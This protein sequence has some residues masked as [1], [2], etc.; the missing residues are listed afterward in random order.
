M[1]LYV[2]ET[3]AVIHR[4]ADHLVV[5][6]NRTAI[7]HAPAEHLQ[8]VVIVGTATITTPALT[9]CFSRDISV[10][11]LSA[12]GS[13]KGQLLPKGG[14]HALLRQRQYERAQDAGFCL[15]VAKAVVT[16]KLRNCRT[17]LLRAARR[18]ASGAR[19][20]ADGLDQMVRAAT[21]ASSID[22][23]RGYE[24][25]GAARYFE[26]FAALLSEPAVFTGRTRRPP[27]DP[28]NALLS[29]G[30]TLL[31][32]AMI[33]L[34]HATGLDPYRGIFHSIDEGHAALASDLIE[35][36]RP[37]I[38]DS[39]VLEMVNRGGLG[40]EDF[41]RERDRVVLSR[42]GRAK[43]LR[44]YDRRLYAEVH[45][46]RSNERTTYLRCLQGQAR[47]LAKVVLGEQPQYVPFVVR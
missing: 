5:T 22:S 29:F 18:G 44:Q 17:L 11:F 3:G 43:F 37:V 6:K 19:H 14:T 21:L 4:R 26:G 42:G 10:V 40:D 7:G 32:G 33:G 36:F 1:I 41:V 39:I 38:V 27:R 30:Y 24:G 12:H 25:E 47:H 34:L 45:H 2:T 23:V 35:E 31:H 46:P 9:W 16:G 15:S 28:V 20:A 8:G 13:Y